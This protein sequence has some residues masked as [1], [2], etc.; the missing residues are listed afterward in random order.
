MKCGSKA[1]RP[2]PRPFFYRETANMKRVKN[3]LRG[4]RDDLGRVLVLWAVVTGIV[5]TMVLNYVL[6]LE[7]LGP[8]TAVYYY[9]IG[10]G[11]LLLV[12]S[13]VGWISTSPWRATIGTAFLL[14]GAM[15]FIVGCT[16]GACPVPEH[17]EYWRNIEFA[18]DAG[19]VGPNLLVDSRPEPC[20][21]GCPYE[22]QVIP[23]AIGYGAL[24]FAAIADG[25]YGNSD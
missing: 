18:I 5:A 23:L 24:A 17:Y 16:G 9:V 13:Y 14:W 12:G 6:P 25:N 4:F 15:M 2:N 10:P 22:I 11:L 7:F 8:V 1:L 20:A 19:T 3:N 21:F